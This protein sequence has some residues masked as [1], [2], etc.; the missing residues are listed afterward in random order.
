MRARKRR[1]STKNPMKQRIQ[2]SHRLR[3]RQQF[4]R[5]KS[6][7]MRSRRRSFAVEEIT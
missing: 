2:A 5:K 1:L 6:A 3:I 4:G 7:C